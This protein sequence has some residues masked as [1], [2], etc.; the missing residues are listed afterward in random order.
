MISFLC[1]E[2]NEF[3]LPAVFYRAH[4]GLPIGRK[5]EENKEIGA[6]KRNLQL[7][8]QINE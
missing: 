5:F 3:A 6:F 8:R 1:D 7:C 4:I 2:V